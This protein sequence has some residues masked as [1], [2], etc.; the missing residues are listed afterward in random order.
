MSFVE[1]REFPVRR[2][3]CFPFCAFGQKHYRKIK[4][5][6]SRRNCYKLVAKTHRLACG[7]K[8]TYFLLGFYIE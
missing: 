3:L 6:Q 1:S 2:S 4:T 8:A 7:M 5:V